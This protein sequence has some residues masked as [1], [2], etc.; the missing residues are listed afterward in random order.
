MHIVSYQIKEVILLTLMFTDLPNVTMTAS[1]TT[2]TEGR[3]SLTLNCEVDSNP[4]AT[5]KWFKNIETEDFE[6]VG[7]GTELVIS[8][9]SRHNAG[10]YTCLATNII[11]ESPRTQRDS[12]SRQYERTRR[13]LFIDVQCKYISAT[14]PW[15][16]LL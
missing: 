3:D 16:P 9:I 12:L 1:K 4:P 5:I 11:G 15:V 8:P 2:L 7:S 6:E 10:T 14:I 13:S